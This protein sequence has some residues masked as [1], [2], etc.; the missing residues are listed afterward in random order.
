MDVDAC[1]LADQRQHRL[2][3]PWWGQVDRRIALPDAGGP[4]RCLRR[5][6]DELLGQVHHVVVVGERLVG[7]EHRELGVV[8]SAQPLVAEHPPDFEDVLVPADEQ[9]LEGQLE[10]DPEREVEVERVVV[11]EE[12][13]CRRAADDLME[14][15]CFHLDEGVLLEERSEGVD[16]GDAHVEHAP[17]FLVHDEVDVA[18]PEP[19]VDV[20]KAVPLVGER[21]QRLGEELERRDLDGELALL[22]L[23]DGA[24]GTD[25]VA[26]VEVVEGG[27][28]FVAD[29]R[30]GHE[31]LDSSR[32]VSHGRERELALAPD[33]H[34]ASRDAHRVV[35][36]GAG[37]DA[38]VRRVQLCGR[39]GA[40]K[41]HRVRIATLG[42]EGLDL[43]EAARP[44]VL[45][46]AQR[47][48][49]NTI[50][51]PWR[52]SQGS[53]CW[54]V[55]ENGTMSSA[56]PPVATTVQSPSS[57]WNRSTSASICPVKP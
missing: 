9:T 22:R 31:Q 51:S 24:L 23:H 50:R 34:Q 42:A 40:V 4:H 38:S 47:F 26:E 13:L 12:G 56:S 2:A 29:H 33:E 6:R 5:V 52:V 46:F 20:G 28:A 37:V 8:P 11:R 7:L 54:I 55:R 19:G 1:V 25:P 32:A 41:A 3:R 30:P 16:G 27:V 10:R 53:L 57:A 15:G 44:L 18:L 17:G 21:P 36:L 45:E 48:L 39:V 43:G 14:D 35:D 49:S